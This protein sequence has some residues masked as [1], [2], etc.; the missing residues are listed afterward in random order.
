ML[1][2]NPDI[3]LIG[4]ND[5]NEKVVKSGLNFFYFDNAFLKTS[6]FDELINTSVIPVFY[7]DFDLLFSGYVSTNFLQINSNITIIRPN[8]DDWDYVL[9]DVI[10]KI[11][12]QKS[13][14]IIDSLN[15]LFTIFDDIESSRFVNSCIMLL[16]SLGNNVGSSI[17]VG[18]IAKFR[19]EDGWVLVPTAR[20]IMNIKN[21]KRFS[22][23]ESDSQI[24]I[25]QIEN[26]SVKDSYKILISDSVNHN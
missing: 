19:K 22:L 5:L 8:R 13:L 24:V 1:D 9:S 26:N 2:K 12:L 10:Q 4:F 3:N 6:V 25:Q 20:R 15:G 14:V 7:F 23:K 21:S 16:N 11:S 17:I 18:T